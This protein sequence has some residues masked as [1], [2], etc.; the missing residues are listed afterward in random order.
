[1][2]YDLRTP[3]SSLQFSE[4]PERTAALLSWVNMW[5]SDTALWLLTAT[6]TRQE[7]ST[8]SPTQGPLK[9]GVDSQNKGH[10]SAEYNQRMVLWLLIFYVYG[11]SH[12]ASVCRLL[13]RIY[14]SYLLP[15]FP[16]PA[17]HVYP[18]FYFPDCL[19]FSHIS[20]LTF[21]PW[22]CFLPLLCFGIGKYFAGW[23]LCLCDDTVPPK[24]P[25]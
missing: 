5:W 16:V 14:L 1:M 19:I 22:G 15:T 21:F 23:V 20:F 18:L 10:T 3:D 11:S 25:W 8:Q 6:K 17:S 12:K 9:S 7:P 24:V 4:T 13:C 2:L